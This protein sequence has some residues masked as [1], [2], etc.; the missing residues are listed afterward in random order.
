MNN[1]TKTD[2]YQLLEISPDATSMDIINAYRQAKLTYKTDSMAAY[3]LFDDTELAQIQADIEQAYDTLSN[4]EKRLAYDTERQLAQTSR[5]STH[6]AK[7]PEQDNAAALHDTDRQQQDN[8]VD[9]AS[10][11]QSAAGIRYRMAVAT[12]FSGPLLREIR[13]FKGVELASIADHTKISRQ[14]LQAIEDE[15]RQHLPEAAYL[16][17]YLKQYAAEIGLD[18]ERVV[19]HYP[20]LTE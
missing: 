6:P 20:P 1:K 13:E 14:Y 15:D 11:A 10:E 9:L 18:P 7:S 19:S 12:V 4:A 2:F 17:G 5:A 3:S 8:V 16:K